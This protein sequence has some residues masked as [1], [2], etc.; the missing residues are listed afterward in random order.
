VLNQVGILTNIALEM[1]SHQKDPCFADE[2]TKHDTRLVE[3]VLKCFYF[4]SWGLILRFDGGSSPI[5][6]LSSKP[7]VLRA[8]SLHGWLLEEMRGRT[9]ATLYMN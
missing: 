2:S 1:I 4:Y 7:A 5:Y 8:R 6:V 3:Y 9:P